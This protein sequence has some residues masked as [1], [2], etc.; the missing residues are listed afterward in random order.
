MPNLSTVFS[1]ANQLADEWLREL[2]AEE[3][4]KPVPMT[5]KDDPVALAWSVYRKWKSNLSGSRWTELELAQATPEDHAQAALIRKYY[6]D[7]IVIS[8]LAAKNISSFRRKLYGVVTDSAPLNKED[9]GL[10]YRL[11]YFYEEDT[12][13]DR[14]VEQTETVTQRFDD[15][16]I[17][18]EFTVIERVARSRR[19]GDYTQYWMRSDICPNAFMMTV[20]DDNPYHKLIANL[21]EKPIRLR[22]H[23]VPK[24]HQG[25]HR[26]RAY[27]YLAGIEV[28]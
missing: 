21:M 12:A 6:A 5:F 16:Q 17:C 20:K 28:A 9:I 14:V 23:A 13:L 4:K 22:G 7:R 19:A 10:L 15:E 2:E 3:T 26:N 18:A 1:K 25:Y 8:M 24:T 27:Y 11:P